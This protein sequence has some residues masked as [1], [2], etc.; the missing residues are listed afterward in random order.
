MQL[1]KTRLLYNYWAIWPQPKICTQKS[2]NCKIL[3]RLALND[4]LLWTFFRLRQQ[5]NKIM[6]TSCKYNNCFYFKT[7]YVI[8]KKKNRRFGC[9]SRCSPSLHL[10]Q[11]LCVEAV[12]FRLSCFLFGLCCGFKPFNHKS[13]TYSSKSG[14]CLFLVRRYL[15]FASQLYACISQALTNIRFSFGFPFVAQIG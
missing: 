5:C 15:I 10:T 14:H 6:T 4:R 7:Y 1:K 2:G 13:S 9:Q 12:V 8:E 11:N 3:S